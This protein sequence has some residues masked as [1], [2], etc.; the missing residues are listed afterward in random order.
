MLILHVSKWESSWNITD[1]YSN[2]VSLSGLSGL[3]GVS[4]SGLFSYFS[5][6]F[7]I[8]WQDID[9]YLVTKYVR[10]LITDH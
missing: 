4:L 7:D 6:G 2:T 10:F 9:R 1:L 3:C 5:S 8:G